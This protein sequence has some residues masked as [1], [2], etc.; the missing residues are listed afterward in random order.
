MFQP[1]IIESKIALIN[2]V[3]DLFFS[4]F[5]CPRSLSPERLARCPDERRDRC[6]RVAV[7]RMRGR[8]AP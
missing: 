3:F 6:L 1:N 5:P 7:A 4:G 2:R 8:L